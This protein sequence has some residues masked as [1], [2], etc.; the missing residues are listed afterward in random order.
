MTFTI[1]K[2][3]PPLSLASKY[4]FAEMQ[5]RDAFDFP[6][7]QDWIKKRDQIRSAA[8]YWKKAFG[9]EAKFSV[10]LINEITGRCRRNA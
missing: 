4:P 7:A 10:R 2:D 1:I 5:I 6:V 8:N 9:S 3:T